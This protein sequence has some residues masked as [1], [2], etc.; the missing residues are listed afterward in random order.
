MVNK[1]LN[2]SN[3]I[4]F[5]ISSALYILYSERCTLFQRIINASQPQRAFCNQKRTNTP[6]GRFKN[7]I[8][9]RGCA[10]FFSSYIILL[11]YICVHLF[12]TSTQHR[13]K[14]RISLH[15]SVARKIIYTCDRVSAAWRRT[16]VLGI[17]PT[18]SLLQ[19]RAAH[20]IYTRHTYVWCGK[21]KLNAHADAAP[22]LDGFIIAPRTR[23]FCLDNNSIAHQPQHQKTRT[24]ILRII[25]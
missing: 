10:N 18:V 14:R 15:L 20:I 2:F 23:E 24:H 21:S 9:A 11:T 25:I 8:F 16:C 17:L 22:H 3:K 19:A 1:I 4:Q 7:N 6:R 12:R 13:V 5:D